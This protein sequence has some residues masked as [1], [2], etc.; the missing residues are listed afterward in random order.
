MLACLVAYGLYLYDSNKVE[1]SPDTPKPPVSGMRVLMV[2]DKLA[3]GQ[4]IAQGGAAG[5]QLQK[6]VNAMESGPVAEYLQ[7]HCADD[8][9]DG[10]KAWRLY[11]VHQD[12]SKEDKI[13]QDMMARPRD[14]LPWIYIDKGLKHVSQP[15]PKDGNLLP[16]LQKV[17]G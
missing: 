6:Q 5:E 11:D 12:I 1:P 2:H 17:G 7:T 3:E 16:V 10:H 4:I 13:W 15:I 9:S 14:S 8:A